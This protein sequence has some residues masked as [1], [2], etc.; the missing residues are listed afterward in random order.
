MSGRLGIYSQAAAGELPLL[1]DLYPNAA[2]AY[3]LR[4]L[5]AGYTGAIVEIRRD[6][7]NALKD[8]YPDASNELSLTSED[9]AGTSLATWIGANN[10]FVRTWYEQSGNANDA[11][12]TN[13]AS[14]PQVISSG[15]II[16]I[17]GKPSVR[18]LS[19]SQYLNSANASE[20]NSVT[21]ASLF[22]VTA[23]DTLNA[24]NQYSCGVRITTNRGFLIGTETSGSSARFHYNPSSFGVVN[25]GTLV[26]STQALIT[27]LSSAAGGSI[28]IDG[29][30]VGSGAT[31]YTAGTTNN[32]FLGQMSSLSSGGAR[33]L[34]EFIAYPS[35]E[36][37]NKAGIETNINDYFSI[38]INA[39]SNLVP[40]L[41]GTSGNTTNG[42]DVWSKLRAFYPMCPIDAT[43]F[44]LDACKWN[45]INPLDTDAAFRMTWVNSPTVTYEG[46]KGDGTS[47]YGNTHFVES[48]QMTAGNNGMTRDS[49][50]ILS[51]TAQIIAGADYPDFA[52]RRSNASYSGRLGIVHTAALEICTISRLTPTDFTVYK[53]GASVANVAT[54]STTQANQPM[55]VFAASDSSGNP[56]IPMDSGLTAFAIHDGLT[57]NEAQDISDAITNFNTALGR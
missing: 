45:L 54:S 32:Y 30:T 23:F 17:N 14:Q 26:A 16:A 7:D 24:G 4:L 2:A 18:F 35:D 34:Q 6:S 48:A 8:F 28:S 51:G 1:L 25:G 9:G 50:D 42:T 15:S 19:S 10:G 29:S 44:T 47:A 21:E 55:F 53:D 56:T 11:L 43:T 5:K 33:N 3:S 49:F 20:F 12:N 13:T 27:G 39:M 52:F 36:G 31:T 38:Y 46:V 37:S 40:D 41:K 22:S 57:A